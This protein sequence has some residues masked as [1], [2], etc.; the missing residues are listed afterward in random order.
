MSAT[1]TKKP[2][3]FLQY[4][5]TIGIAAMEGRGFYYPRD[6]AIG[7]DGRLYVASRSTDNAIR[8]VRVTMCNLDSEFLG[9]FGSFGS[10]QGQFTTPAG[11][12]VD[13]AGRVYLSDES[14]HRISVFGPDG[15]FLSMFGEHGSGPAQFDWPSGMAFDGDDNLYVSDTQNNRVQMFTTDRR[16][17]LSFGSEGSEDGQF[18]LPWGLT[19]APGGDVYVADW[20][21]D[22]V[23]R[24]SASGQFIARYGT[25]GRRDGEFRRPSGVAVDERGYIYVSDWGNERVQVLGPDGEFVLKLRGEGTVSKWAEEFL[26]SN[27]E[28]AEARSRSDLEPQLPIFEGNPHRE[29]SHVEKYF[30]APV[31]VKLDSEARLYV[32]D[33]NRHRV[34]VYQRGP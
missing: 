8:G 15:G 27:V 1:D 10:D 6:T 19:V 7:N 24:F 34:Q 13:S 23:Q 29:S 32:T 11:L 16:F 30:W 3:A 4:S 25:S 20:G 2:T 21:N 17:V 18:H 22:R 5:H 31:S 26:T 28:E 14:L 33:S 12:A 9:V